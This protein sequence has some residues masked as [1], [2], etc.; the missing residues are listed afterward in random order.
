M[1]LKTYTPK[2]VTHLLFTFACLFSL[3]KKNPERFDN[4]CNSKPAIRFSVNHVINNDANLYDFDENKLLNF[5]N[6]LFCFPYT[7]Y[8]KFLTVVAKP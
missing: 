4:E 2:C 7:V 1:L 5:H 6:W 8:S 3:Q